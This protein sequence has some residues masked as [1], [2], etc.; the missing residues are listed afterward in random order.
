[1]VAVPE[2]LWRDAENA[3]IVNKWTRIIMWFF[4]ITIGVPTCVG[5]LGKIIGILATFLGIGGSIFTAYIPF[6]IK[7]FTK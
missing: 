3:K 6:I 1:M 5:L 7:I 4:A 2:E